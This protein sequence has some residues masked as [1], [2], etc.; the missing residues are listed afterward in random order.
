MDYLFSLI[1]MVQLLFT[2]LTNTAV[3]FQ[4]QQPTPQAIPVATYQQ[5]S[6]PTAAA[7]TPMVYYYHP[8]KLIQ[9]YELKPIAAY[10]PFTMPEKKSPMR[11][12]P[13]PAPVASRY[14]A[15]G[16]PSTI[17]GYPMKL[18]PL[19][20]FQM[21]QQKRNYLQQLDFINRFGSGPSASSA[22]GT[23]QRKLTHFKPS[24]MDFGFRPMI[25]S[26]YSTPHS[27]VSIN[28]YT[29]D[30]NVSP[31]KYGYVRDYV[32]LLKK[33]Q[34]EHFA[35]EDPALLTFS[36]SPQIYYQKGGTFSN[37]DSGE[38]K[39]LRPH[40]S[41]EE[42]RPSSQKSPEIQYFKQRESEIGKQQQPQN[43]QRPKPE[44]PPRNNNELY[45]V[46]DDNVDDPK[47]SDP[48]SN[49]DPDDVAED[50][51]DDEGEVERHVSPTEQYKEDYRDTVGHDPE[52]DEGENE[53]YSVE[54]PVSYDDYKNEGDISIEY[55][56]PHRNN[57]DQNYLEHSVEDPYDEGEEESKALETVA[58]PIR[59]Y[60]QVRHTHKKR[61]LPKPAD[62]PRIREK[63]STGK[64]HIVYKEEGYEDKTYDHGDEEK[65]SELNNE[66]KPPRRKR[67]KRI[68]QRRDTEPQLTTTLKPE[69]TSITT[70]EAKK[71]DDFSRLSRD[72]K[73]GEVVPYSTT[74][75]LQRHSRRVINIPTNSNVEYLCKDGGLCRSTTQVVEELVVEKVPIE[76]SYYSK[77][78]ANSN[79][80][81]EGSKEVSS[82]E[83]SGEHSQE[84]D[85]S[86]EIFKFPKTTSD[87]DQIEETTHVM[88]IPLPTADSSLPQAQHLTDNRPRGFVAQKEELTSSDLLRRLSELLQNST[89]LTPSNG[90][91]SDS[92]Q[93]ASRSSELSVTLP[94]AGSNFEKY[95]RQPKQLEYKSLYRSKPVPRCE[96]DEIPNL[97][98]DSFN[99]SVKK[100]G[101]QLGEKLDC[102]KNAYFGKDPFDHPFFNEELEKTEVPKLRKKLNND[103]KN[104]SVSRTVYDDIMNN[105]NRAI[106]LEQPET[107]DSNPKYQTP[108]P[109]TRITDSEI[110]PSIASYEV[111][112][113]NTP[114]TYNTRIYDDDSLLND[115]WKPVYKSSVFPPVDSSVRPSSDPSEFTF[116]S[117]NN[118]TDQGTQSPSYS[119]KLKYQPPPPRTSPATFLQSTALPTTRTQSYQPKYT[120]SPTYSSPIRNSGQKAQ[121]S[122]K[123]SP[124]VFPEATTE[125]TKSSN[126]YEIKGFQ[127]MPLRET[128]MPPYPVFDINKYYPKT[129]Q[130]STNFTTQRPRHTTPRV[131]SS[132]YRGHVSFTTTRPL[133]HHFD[134]RPQQT[135][136]RSKLLTRPTFYRTISPAMKQHTTRGPKAN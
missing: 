61:R 43:Y 58:P 13:I 111:R 114:S 62:D 2:T 95:F 1:I 27:L 11:P 122:V 32:D 51:D 90:S 78:L 115:K 18:S 82:R 16:P 77:N 97:S 124:L 40:A 15:H 76:S 46:H 130:K 47:E 99:G 59:V 12:R 103:K 136:V 93:A 134:A 37:E 118:P 85:D 23:P 24:P 33:R 3:G 74:D 79:E 34:R 110:A 83:T 60:S 29:G 104:V 41:V 98:D 109:R 5:Q 92:E 81:E 128:K 94:N 4:P 64:T 54:R 48:V 65:H 42:E 132:T 126:G 30:I 106:R 100:R 21:D 112:D 108:P 73:L 50:D 102:L 101:G 68:R 107:F 70:S 113:Q 119:Y 26:S 71:S 14:V 96:A 125:A 129:L 35:T 19:K 28:D 53:N 91:D 87:E 66:S 63:V 133:S 88:K 80:S 116:Q 75:G 84:H 117:F 49:N 57:F 69:N 6:P 45:K 10:M 86:F 17:S 44:D 20:S 127:N 7:Q 56:D 31:H 39:Y 89:L 8:V 120:Q 72:L 135:V 131:P 121:S 9:G 22:F 25:K 36:P 67:K 52:E 123:F 38:T 105:I 55:D